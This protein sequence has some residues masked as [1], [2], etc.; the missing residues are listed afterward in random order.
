MVIVFALTVLIQ[1][2]A[3]ELIIFFRFG[4]RPSLAFFHIVAGIGLMLT[5]VLNTGM[6]ECYMD[7]T[8]FYIKNYNKFEF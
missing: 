4:R 2:F 1:V 6:G 7:V 3:F 8:T 5:L